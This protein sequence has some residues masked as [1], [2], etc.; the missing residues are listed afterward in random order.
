MYIHNIANAMKRRY[1][2]KQGVCF[3][4]RDVAYSDI[5]LMQVASMKTRQMLRNVPTSVRYA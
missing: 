2:D 1:V 3:I 5:A 4:S